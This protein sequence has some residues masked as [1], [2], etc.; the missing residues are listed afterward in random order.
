MAI[1]AQRVTLLEET[2]PVIKTV[3]RAIF[4]AAGD[5]LVLYNQHILEVLDIFRIDS[6]FVT[7]D[8]Y[9]SAINSKGEFF[10]GR[11]SS[12]ILHPSLELKIPIPVT[13]KK[14]SRVLRVQFKATLPDTCSL[15]PKTLL[16]KGE[17]VLA[18]AL[19]L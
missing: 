13:L 7:P 12:V 8:L 15:M 5:D 16:I 14:V 3:H 2:Q 9:W 6:L 4:A 11:E 18:K 1:A 17:P 10:D 19:Q